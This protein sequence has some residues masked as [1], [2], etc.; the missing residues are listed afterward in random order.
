MTQSTFNVTQVP[1]REENINPQILKR[2]QAGTMQLNVVVL[3]CIESQPCRSCCFR[4]WARMILISHHL[5]YPW[6][7]ASEMS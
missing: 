6:W 2:H 4:A 1:V 3:T 7:S 5:R